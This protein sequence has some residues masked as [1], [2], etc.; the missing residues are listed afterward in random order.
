MITFELFGALADGRNVVKYTITNRYG[1]SAAI[2][3]YGAALHE[4][5]I[6]DRNGNIGDILLGEP[7]AKSLSKRSREG[8]I[9][10]RVAN[11]ISGASCVIEGKTYEFE[12][13]ERGEFLH[14]GSG[15]YATKLFDATVENE[16]TLLL[17]Y[18]DPGEAGFSGKVDVQ[19]RYTFHDDHCLSIEYRMMPDE[20]TILCPTNHAYF[21]L[22]G[23]MDVRGDMLT[24]DAER[25]A[26]KDAFGLPYG[27]TLPVEN[28]I[29]DFRREKRIAQRTEAGDNVND[30]YCLSGEGYRRIAILKNPTSGRIME[31]WTD[32]P[33][34]VLYIPGNCN[35][36]PGKNGE[37][38]P[39]FGAV[40]IECQYM[41]NAV[42][43]EGFEKGIFG[44]G[45]VFESKTAYCFKTF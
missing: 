35:D 17:H 26:K 38:Y 24:I 18:E 15:N 23:Y 11:R 44:A 9:I 39:A 33:S 25:I 31:T 22:G 4:L 29:Y 8:F 12:R 14:S 21:N 16:N 10:G 13:N 30:Y 3:N 45:E 20:T 5:C 37:L 19:I 41:A 43:C 1:E 28:T 40:C 2:L 32:M 7:D 34:I 27:E 6:L 36:R 42:N